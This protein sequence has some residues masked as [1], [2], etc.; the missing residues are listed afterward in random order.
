MKKET[1]EEVTNT[2]PIA[3]TAK[4]VIADDG[5]HLFDDGVDKG[6]CPND[7]F[8]YFLPE[9]SANRKWFSIKKLNEIKAKGVTE[10]VLAYKATRKLGPIGTHI[11]NEKLISYLPEDLQAEYRAIIDRAIAARE[12]AKTKPMTELEKA[13]AKLAKA[14]AAYE[15]LMA[16]AAGETK[17]STEA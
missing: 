6:I 10:I 15:K 5:V 1:V 17:E 4:I 14:Q 12:E 8:G 13:Q 16:E 11:P 2:T 3:V 7:D 9:N